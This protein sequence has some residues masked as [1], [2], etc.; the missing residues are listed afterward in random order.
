MWGNWNIGVCNP[1]RREIYGS[2][3][4]E[5]CDNTQ[6]PSN[7]MA[8]SSMIKVAD[9]K[10]TAHCKQ[11]VEIILVVIGT[12]IMKVEMACTVTAAVEH[13]LDMRVVRQDLIKQIGKKGVKL[14]KSCLN[15]S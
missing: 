5:F 3:R 10:S 4:G 2:T 14:G 9:T 8:S 11:N 1:G 6:V 15:S 7:D 13:L 12:S